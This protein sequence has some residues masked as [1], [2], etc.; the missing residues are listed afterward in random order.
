MCILDNTNIDT[1]VIVTFK[2]R[3]KTFDFIAILLWTGLKSNIWTALN[4]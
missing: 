2:G 1:D 4:Q 3:E